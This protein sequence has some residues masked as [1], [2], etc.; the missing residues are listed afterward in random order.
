MDFSTH[1]KIAARNVVRN[2]RR[3]LVTF[4]SVVI[5]FV[6]LSLFEGYFVSVYDSLEDQAIVGERLGHLTIARK[7]FFQNGAQ[8]PQSYAFSKDELAT[9]ASK[10]DG[11]GNV[12]LVSPRLSL[13]GLISNGN[14]SRIYIGEG[15]RPEDM[16]VLRGEKYANLPGMLDANQ[17]G[18]AILGKRLA[19]NLGLK[20]G[21]DATLMGST[22]D[23]LVNA[24]GVTLLAQTSTGN[25]GTDDKYVL[26][27]LASAQRLM[28]FEGAERIVVLLKDPSTI[29]ESTAAIE[30][31]MLDL[32]IAC[33]VR[34][35]KTLS[36]YYG[37]V[38]GL[39]DAM[40]LFISIVVAIVVIASVFNTISMTIAERTREVGTLRALG[41]QIGSI[42]LLFVLEGM[43]VV[44]A[45]CLAGAAITLALGGLINSAGISYTPPDASE[46]VPLI[47]KLV[48]ENLFGS[49]F[50]LVLLSALASYLPARRASRRAI[51][52]ALGH[53]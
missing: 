22:L 41:M 13:S 1:M 30:A 38:K 46:A 39:F 25:I 51:T 36:S 16:T 32:G 9:I 48:G 18:A 20:T 12:A 3:S 8:D 26:A 4:L 17:P 44:M 19:E 52:E 27:T 33:E 34:D 37:Q 29:V 11:L 42:D 49:L 28:A 35:W 14:S 23:G 24:V 7:G 43:L 10:L 2:R 31:A 53:V 6:A 45:G 15:I 47:V 50:T 5:G 21:D 40:Y